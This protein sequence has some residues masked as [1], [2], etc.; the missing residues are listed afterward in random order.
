MYFDVLNSKI[1]QFGSKRH[2]V[3]E[4]PVY[5]PK[6]VWLVCY[7]GLC[8]VRQSANQ[9]VSQASS[10]SDSQSGK[11]AGRQKHTVWG[12][13]SGRLAFKQWGEQLL[14]EEASVKW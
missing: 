12:F 2:Y 3:R 4:F 9:S 10:Q 1:K 11:Q 5:R 13:F 8:S 7:S 14:P 6:L